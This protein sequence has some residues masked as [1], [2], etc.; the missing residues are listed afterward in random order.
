MRRFTKPNQQ[1][2]PVKTPGV[3]QIGIDQGGI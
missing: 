3:T 2:I 1:S